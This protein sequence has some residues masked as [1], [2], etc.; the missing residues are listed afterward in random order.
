MKTLKAYCVSSLCFV[1]LLIVAGTASAEVV[2]FR[3]MPRDA[4]GNTALV[5]G[6]NGAVGERQ[7]WIGGPLEPYYRTLVPTHMVTFIH[8]YTGQKLNV[9]FTFPDSSARVEYRP[10][11]VIYNYGTY[12]IHALFN[13]DGSVTTIY[14][15]GVLRPVAFQ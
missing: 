10:N 4:C 11:R 1:L 8:P 14:N 12:Q 9:P 3:Y 13:P 5:P 7:A 15:S 6:P 2:R